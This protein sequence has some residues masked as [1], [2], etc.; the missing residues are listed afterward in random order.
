MLHVVQNSNHLNT[1]FRL[2]LPEKLLL[3]ILLFRERSRLK[4]L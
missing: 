2:E 3:D 1:L 4:L